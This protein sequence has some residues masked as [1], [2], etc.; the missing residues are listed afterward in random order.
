MLY[1]RELERDDLPVINRWRNDPK[2]IA[3]LGAPFRYINP[4][5][6][7]RWFET[8][9]GNRGNAVRCVIMEEGSDEILGLVSLVSIN[10]INQSAEFHIMIGDIQNQGRGIG[11]YAVHAMLRHAF[12]NMNLQRVELSVLEDN[13]RAKHLYEKCGFVYE[14]RKRK[15]NYKDGKFVDMLMYSILKSEFYANI[16]MIV[17][18][19]FWGGGNRIRTWCIE[20]AKNQF[21]IDCIIKECDKAFRNPIAK[22]KIYSDLLPKLSQKGICMMAYCKEVMGYCAFYANDYVGKKA[23]ISLL[24]VKQKYQGMH[25]GSHLLNKCMEMAR[26]YGMTACMLEVDKNNSF[27]IEFYGRKG[28]AL[29]EERVDSLLMRIELFPKKKNA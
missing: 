17:G 26:S 19:S 1:L 7:T 4:E 2:L 24:A 14:G 16:G 8:Y 6:D 25:I 11:T 21:E 23:Y 27:A 9:M 20:Q 5:V 18:N 29:I 28:F 15:A 12:D 13:E 10:Y 3:L 22:R